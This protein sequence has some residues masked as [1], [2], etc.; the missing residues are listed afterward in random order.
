M[1]RRMHAFLAPLLAIVATQY[2]ASPAVFADPAVRL[3]DLVQAFPGRL[4]G[5]PGSPE[6]E[7]MGDYLLGVNDQLFVIDASDPAHPRLVRSFRPTDAGNIDYVEVAGNIAWLGGD[8]LIAM[9]LSDPLSPVEIARFTPRFRTDDMALGVV[10]GR[11][12]LV[13][14]SGRLFE[15]L[16][17][18]D[19]RAPVY[20]GDFEGDS[21]ALMA[22][23]G[24]HLLLASGLL[25]IYD[26]SDPDSPALLGQL[27]LDDM[28]RSVDYNNG[29]AFVVSEPDGLTMID[30][31]DPTTPSV[32]GRY[33]ATNAHFVRASGGVALLGATSA[34]DNLVV[35]VLDVRDPAE[36]APIRSYPS[37]WTRGATLFGRHALL[38]NGRSL[39]QPT[40]ITTLN[41][42]HPG[43]SAVLGEPWQSPVLIRQ[44]IAA[45]GR[46]AFVVVSGRP[47]TLTVLEYPAAPDPGDPV[48]VATVNPQDV[49]ERMEIAGDLLVLQ[50]IDSLEIWS[51]ADPAAPVRRSVTFVGGNPDSLAVEDGL[52]YVVD[53]GDN[54]FLVLD[55]ADPPDPVLLSATRGLRPRDI[56]AA[57]PIIVGRSG[58]AVR[59]IDATD[60]AAPLLAGEY[61]S[62][63]AIDALLAH[64]HPTLGPIA[65]VATSARLLTLGLADPANPIVL[66]ES[67]ALYPGDAITLHRQGDVVL[68]S[69]T[70]RREKYLV[71]VSDPAATRLIGTLFDRDAFDAAWLDDSLL[72][73]SPGNTIRRLDFRAPTS[74]DADLDGNGRLDVFDFLEF[75]NRFNAQDPASDYTADGRFTMLDFAA[76]LN[77]FDGGCR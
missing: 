77:L 31:S 63:Q 29:I 30:V 40:S 59:V 28:A 19:P 60:P 13:L 75:I 73:S 67:P 47:D 26:L 64:D 39:G 23:A 32:L 1:P 16:D 49:F 58:R 69:P 41:L 15:I 3:L 12:L 66:F 54:E 45:R 57:G 50:T 20:R 36:I 35:E 10:G 21:F 6:Y 38:A 7:R 9:D 8:R 34:P 51:I 76:Y 70:D 2:L 11:V 55:I 65:Y 42:S 56:D 22:F 5:E 46:F 72:L 43:G 62:D 4:N 53:G 61:R 71:D 48:V 68:V 33:R 52:V 14:R 44:D 37:T 25:E 74:C 27:T 24:G 18:T 17:V